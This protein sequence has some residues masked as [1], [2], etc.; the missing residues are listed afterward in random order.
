MSDMKKR[1]WEMFLGTRG[2]EDTIAELTR[3]VHRLDDAHD[4]VNYI[5]RMIAGGPCAEAEDVLR[6]GRTSI[7]EAIEYLQGETSAIRRTS[8]DV[9]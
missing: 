9:A 1:E 4:A 6:I 3:C 5:L 8:P 7:N 2:S